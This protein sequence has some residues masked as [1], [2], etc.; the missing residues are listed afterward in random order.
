MKT[1][2]I[3]SKD[4]PEYASIIATFKDKVNY[5]Y[6]YVSGLSDLRGLH[7]GEIIITPTATA[8]ADYDQIID[9]VVGAGFEVDES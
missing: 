2:H 1:L 8:R 5:K 7:G 4:Y 6:R 3:L 9:Y